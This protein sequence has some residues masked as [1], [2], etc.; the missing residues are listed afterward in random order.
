M[1][2]TE[3]ERQALLAA[4]SFRWSI[5]GCLV[6]PVEGIKRFKQTQGGACG[7]GYSMSVQPK[8]LQVTIG[9]TTTHVTWATIATF[10]R[11]LPDNLLEQLQ[12]ALEANRERN[13]SY[14]TF[15]CSPELVGCGPNLHN[16]DKEGPLTERRTRYEE[17]W[18]AWHD[19]PLQKYR[20]LVV[21]DE[22]Q[23]DAALK[24]ALD[25]RLVEQL[26]LVIA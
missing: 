2:L 10:A 17:E 15:R 11:S 26:E 8:H 18:W 25:Y 20:A 22:A 1:S 3:S 21:D 16:H 13:R 23:I 14:P 24:A 19:G 5:A 6:D 7:Q 12:A 4:E 9:H